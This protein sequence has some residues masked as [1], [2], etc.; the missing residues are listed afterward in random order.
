M[1]GV[2]RVWP[3]VWFVCTWFVAKKRVPDGDCHRAIF[4]A[5]PLVK[6]ALQAPVDCVF[7]TTLERGSA[8]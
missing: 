6:L 4:L 8:I 7:S 3:E 1:P 5:R 2:A